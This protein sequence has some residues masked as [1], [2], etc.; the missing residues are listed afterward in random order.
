MVMQLRARYQLGYSYELIPSFFPSL[1]TQGDAKERCSNTE[2]RKNRSL[3]SAGNF[4][5]A[6]TALAMVHWNFQ[7]AGLL[8]CRQHLHL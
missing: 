4:R 3:E 5:N 6:A 8:L 2:P 1:L 7:D